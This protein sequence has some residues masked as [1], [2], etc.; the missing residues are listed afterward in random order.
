MR[1]L[2]VLPTV[3][4]AIAMLLTALAGPVSATPGQLDHF[5][6]NTGKTT[7]F[8]AGGTGYA[9]AI[10]HMGRILVAGYTLTPSADLALARFLPDG[11]P[12]PSFGN[13]TG[14][15]ITNLGG[16]DY[17]FDVAIQSN[18]SI[19]VAGERD[20][21]NSSAFAVVRYGIHGVLDPTFGGDG[22]VFI[23]FGRRYQGANAVAV[24]GSGNIVVGGYAS[25]GTAS[26]W[27]LA[28]LKPN[29]TLDPT[30]G[31]GGKVFTDLSA[32]NEALEDLKIGAGGVITATGF[33]EFNLV[34]RF[35]VTQ[36]LING[37]L[38]P[39]FGNGGKNFIDVSAGSD[40]A[41]ALARQRDG[42][43]VIAGYAQHGGQQDWGLVRLG[44][45]GRLDAAF[46]SGGRVITTFPGTQE[47]AYGVVV[48]P[49]GKIVV[50]GRANTQNGADFCVVRYRIAG[51]LD[52]TFGTGGK[53]FTDFSKGEDFARG[54]ALQ[55]NGKIVV[56]GEAQVGG[57]RRMA[58]ARYL[59]T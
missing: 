35:A 22:K 6:N 27:A 48:Q 42:K 24:G 26:Q 1:R 16:T 45:H 31:T 47:Y 39:S 34:P 23:D 29:G 11:T 13:G 56:A 52:T 54:V 43:I 5:F 32:T 3:G 46:G 18:G 25:N 33:A 59:P 14:R 20:L 19:V 38:D 36:Y 55:T 30:F 12:D 57:R 4:I 58:V 41:Y 37:R 44:V 17:A 50:V 21:P 49:N 15:V 7:T 9:V 51:T 53:V 8:V 10:D 40:V 2:R 28:R